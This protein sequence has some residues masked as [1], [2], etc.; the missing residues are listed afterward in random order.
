MAAWHSSITLS[1]L[2]KCQF[3]HDI[4]ISF[5]FSREKNSP[6]AHLK[7]FSRASNLQIGAKS[8]QIRE[9]IQLPLIPSSKLNIHLSTLHFAQTASC[10]YISLSITCSCYQEILMSNNICYADFAIISQFKLTLCL[11]VISLSLFITISIMQGGTP[12]YKQSAPIICL[13]TRKT[14]M[15]SRT[16]KQQTKNY[17]RRSVMR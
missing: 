17:L 1:K 15:W 16:K 11:F 7:Y 4:P 8:H 14:F 6:V 12:M 13:I 9:K 3:F 2:R 10:V 5:K